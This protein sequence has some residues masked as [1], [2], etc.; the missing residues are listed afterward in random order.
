MLFTLGYKSR[1]DPSSLLTLPLVTALSAV[2]EVE[3]CKRL[4]EP[5]VSLLIQAHQLLEAAKDPAA[6]QRPL[7][8]ECLDVNLILLTFSKQYQV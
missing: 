7:G 5:L 4:I 8:E 2:E 6:K 1:P 3:V